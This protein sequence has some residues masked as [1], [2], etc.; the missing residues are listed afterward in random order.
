MLIFHEIG[1]TGFRLRF[2]P[3]SGIRVGFD[4]RHALAGCVFDLQVV[5]RVFGVGFRPASCGI[6]GQTLGLFGAVPADDAPGLDRVGKVARVTAMIERELFE[7]LIADGVQ[8]G[9]EIPLATAA[10]TRNGR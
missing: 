5:T 9:F 1:D 2:V 10:A 6:A 8:L 4:E 3:R 7:R